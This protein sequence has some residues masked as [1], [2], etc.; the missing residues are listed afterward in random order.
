MA[1][2]KENILEHQPPAILILFNTYSNKGSA[3]LLYIA[4]ASGKENILEH[5]PRPS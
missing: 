1:S 3:S 2:G 4:M 5:Q